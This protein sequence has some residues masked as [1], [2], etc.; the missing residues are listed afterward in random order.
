MKPFIEDKKEV[1]ENSVR[2]EK[3][4]QVI[5]ECLKGE[6]SS[7]LFLLQ[8]TNKK[9]GSAMLLGLLAYSMSFIFWETPK[10]KVSTMV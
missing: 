2:K 8:T 3:E 6:K 5:L 4:D 10:F 9:G 7:H 1:L